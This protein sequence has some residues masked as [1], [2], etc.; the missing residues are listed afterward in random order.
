MCHRKA[1][2]YCES[3]GGELDL[4]VPDLGAM[5]GALWHGKKLPVGKNF[6]F[7]NS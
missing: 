4:M 1:P 6:A 7:L 3:R 2:Y 5:E